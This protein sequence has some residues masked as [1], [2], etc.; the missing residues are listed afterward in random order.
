M[1]FQGL[2]GKHPSQLFDWLLALGGSSWFLGLEGKSQWVSWPCFC[3]RSG[4]ELEPLLT[5]S[6]PCLRGVAQEPERLLGEGGLPRAK[7]WRWRTSAFRMNPIAFVWAGG[8]E[9]GEE[10]Q[11]KTP[12]C[13][14]NSYLLLLKAVNTF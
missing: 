11:I 6:F 2:F 4:W 5:L 7:V 13:L 8:N 14:A 12:V 3:F 9:Q 1:P 10:R